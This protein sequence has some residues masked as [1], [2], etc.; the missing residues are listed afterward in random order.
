MLGFRGH[1]ST[2][3]RRYSTTLTALRTARQ[4]WRDT[5]ILSSLG[6]PESYPIYRHN[7]HQPIDDLPRG[8]DTILVLGHWQ[9]VGRGHSPGEARYARTI[10]DDLM[11]ARRT[12]RQQ[13]EQDRVAA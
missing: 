4:Q 3:S 5:Q 1:F 2:K 9:Y 6:L 12:G 11:E 10:S 8:E 13:S 7:G